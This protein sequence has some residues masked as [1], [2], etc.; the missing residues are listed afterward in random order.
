M[1]T[2]T[3]EDNSITVCDGCGRSDAG[4]GSP[5]AIAEYP[6]HDPNLNSEVNHHLCGGCA[7]RRG[8]TEVLTTVIPGWHVVMPATVGPGETQEEH[9]AAMRGESESENNGV[10]LKFADPVSGTDGDVVVRPVDASEV[11]E[12]AKQDVSS[13]R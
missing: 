10:S 2:K 12:E 1:I 9:E 5:L 8:L 11:S 7:R 6:V 4:P 3:A 13:D